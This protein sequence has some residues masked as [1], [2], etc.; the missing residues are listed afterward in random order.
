MGI[1]VGVFLAPLVT[2]VLIEES[3]YPLMWLATALSA[4]IG[5]IIALRIANEF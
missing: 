4:A 3:G 5:S 1:Y 2:G